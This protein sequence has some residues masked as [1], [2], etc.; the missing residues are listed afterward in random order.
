MRRIQR[1]IR[2]VGGQADV[3]DEVR[4]ANAALH[5]FMERRARIKD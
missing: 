2:G 4:E 1:K 3:A 5:H